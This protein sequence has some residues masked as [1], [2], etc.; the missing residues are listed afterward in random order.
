MAGYI[1]RLYCIDIIIKKA[2]FQADG[3]G[4]IEGNVVVSIRFEFQRVQTV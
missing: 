3:E 1:K 4:R 2:S